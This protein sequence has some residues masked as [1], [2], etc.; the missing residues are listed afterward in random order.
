MQ[1][2]TQDDHH[3]MA[4]VLESYRS[5][6]EHLAKH[7][8]MRRNKSMANT[9]NRVQAR[10][11]LKSSK[12]MRNVEIFAH[13]GDEQLAKVIDAMTC[14]S[15]VK[16]D[17]IVKQGE[18]ADVFYIITAGSAEVWQ[19]NLTNML[20]GGAMVG[21]LGALA[22]FG[23]NALVNAVGGRSDPKKLKE[24]RNASVVASSPRCTVMALPGKSLCR[25][26]EE[27]VI[28]KDIFM[29]SVENIKAERDRKTKATRT[30]K[31]AL[32]KRK[33]K[34]A[35]VSATPSDARKIEESRR[36]LPD[37]F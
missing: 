32:A 7:T 34:P 21:E 12:A 1:N 8:N 4:S 25:L 35:G 29:R 31:N 3:T 30:L 14:T 26:L 16:G 24:V 28:N 2:L 17:K 36:L 11:K 33:S 5:H 6:E 9:M 27:G 22:H 20:S 19:K 18:R 13:C 37:T 23:E 15:F 10:R